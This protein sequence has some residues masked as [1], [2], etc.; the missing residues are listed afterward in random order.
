[1][2]RKS[3]EKTYSPFLRE[4]RAKTKEQGP[5]KLKIKECSFLKLQLNKAYREQFAPTIW[6]GWLD[7][8]ESQWRDYTKAKKAWDNR[9]KEVDE[10]FKKYLWNMYGASIANTILNDQ[11]GLDYTENRW[12]YIAENFHGDIY[13]GLKKPEYNEQFEKLTEAD[14]EDTLPVATYAFMN[15]FGINRPIRNAYLEFY[16]GVAGPDKILTTGGIR[17]IDPRVNM[18]DI[19]TEPG[20]SGARKGIEDMYKRFTEIITLLALESRVN[21]Q[22]TSEWLADELRGWFLGIL[23]SWRMP[24]N[25]KKWAKVKG[26]NKP[27]IYTE[28]MVDTLSTR[29]FPVR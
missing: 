1:M 24:R 19:N 12:Y 13:S 4:K 25:S 17:D 26:K 2:A 18:N 16:K 27:L 9:E 21:M 5:F 29:I 8:Y 11:E 20:Y 15:F 7:S 14:F 22:Y 23:M 28:A 3:V 10:G 6:V